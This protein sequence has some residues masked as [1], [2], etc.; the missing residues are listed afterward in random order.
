MSVFFV[1]VFRRKRHVQ[2][3]LLSPEP[4]TD[5]PRSPWRL[6]PFIKRIRQQLLVVR[7]DVETDGDA[8]LRGDASHGGVQQDLPL[9]DAHASGPAVAQAEDAGRVGD[10]D[11]VDRRDW[12]RS[13]SRGRSSR[14]RTTRRSVAGFVVAASTALPPPEV[15]DELLQDP[16]ITDVSRGQIEA[17]GLYREAVVVLA[18]LILFF[19]VFEVSF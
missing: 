9:R 7:P 16:A 12:R 4:K 6:D 19:E 17:H 15:T 18:D 10:D 3:F 11:D 5:L 2:P 14:G 13:S 8:P 1:R